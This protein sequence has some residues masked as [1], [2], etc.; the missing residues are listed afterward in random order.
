MTNNG[1]LFVI[2]GSSG[3]GKGTLIKKFLEKNPQIEYSVSYTTRLPRPDEI[4]G[5]NYFF[6]TRKEFESAIKNNEFIEWAKFSDNYYG[7]KIS[8]VEKA[9]KN[10]TNLILEIETQGALQIMDKFPNAKYIF[11]HPPSAQELEQRLRSRGTE[12]EEAIQKRLS[13][14]KK[15][16][17]ISKLF[18]YQ[19]VNDN[20]DKALEELQK[21]FDG[22]KDV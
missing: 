3:V 4:N 7:T 5:I 17:E 2:T 9:L 11:I 21:I 18:T 13:A 14:A 16:Y 20:I 1:Q 12:T 6:V 8:T 22:N 19:V 15:E 10:G